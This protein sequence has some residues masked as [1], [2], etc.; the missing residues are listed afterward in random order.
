MFSHPLRQTVQQEDRL[1]LPREH[2]RRVS[3]PVRPQNQHGHP[4]LLFYRVRHLHSEGK[5]SLRRRP[6]AAPPGQPEHRT[7]GRPADHGPK[8]WRRAAARR[9]PLGA[10]VQV[11]QSHR[12]VAEVQEGCRRPQCHFFSCDRR[13]EH[14]YAWIDNYVSAVVAVFNS[15]CQ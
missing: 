5:E 12:D 9:R 7:A 15:F 10:G 2:C 13:W 6:W 4:T 3:Q 14:P 11:G 1:H 8:Y